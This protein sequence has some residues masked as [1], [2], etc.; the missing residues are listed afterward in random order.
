V[1]L[2]LNVACD[3]EQIELECDSGRLVDSVQASCRRCGN[4]TQAYGTAS[5]SVRRC[6]V[7]MREECPQHENN[8][9]YASD[10]EDE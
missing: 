8:W 4:Q 1:G 6:L 10:G 5:V 2:Q 3:I 9:Y 7:Q